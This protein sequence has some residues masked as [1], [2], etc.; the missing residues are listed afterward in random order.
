LDKT[1]STWVL[2]GI[3]QT[4]TFNLNPTNLQVTGTLKSGTILATTN[5]TLNIGWQAIDSRDISATPVSAP[6][7]VK[8]GYTCDMVGLQTGSLSF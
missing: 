8:I 5:G 2:N 4:M 7:Q 6:S 3:S 1:V